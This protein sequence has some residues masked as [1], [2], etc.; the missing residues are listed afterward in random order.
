MFITKKSQV[1]I[2][3]AVVTDENTDIFAI[4]YFRK[5]FPFTDPTSNFET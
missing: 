4:A 1:K 5:H 2:T 3:L